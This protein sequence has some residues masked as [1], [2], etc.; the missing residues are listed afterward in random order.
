MKR[1]AP[2]RPVRRRAP[3]VVV[4]GLLLSVAGCPGRPGPG[5][6]SRGPAGAPSS[7]HA[8][9]AGHDGHAEADGHDDHAGHDGHD[10]HAE[11]DAGVVTLT[12]AQAR[13][14]DVRVQ[15]A[16]P[17]PIAQVLRLRAVV[18]PN[19]DAQ[20]HATPRVAGLV[21]AIHK[22]LGD[23]VEAGEVLCE[24]DSVDLG[25]AASEYLQARALLQVQRELL[26][27][28]G[29]LLGRALE[30]ARTVVAR[31]RKLQEQAV[32][33]IR[34]LY[35][36]E[37]RLAEAQLA[38]DR[39]LLEL[40][41]ALRTLEVQA[42]VAHERLLVL[43]LTAA[44]VDGLSATQGAGIGRY[45]LRAAAP[46]VIVDRHVTQSEYVGPEDTLFLLQDGARVWVEAKVYEKDLRAVQVGQ[47]VRVTLEA[48]PGVALEGAVGL[49]GPSVDPTTRAAT[50]RVVLDNAVPGA[51]QPAPLRPGM[52]AKVEVTVAERTADVVLPE[53][54]VVHEGR[55]TFVFVRTG[56]RTYRRQAVQ[57]E[58]A[59]RGVVA[60]VAGLPAGAEVAV[61]GTFTLESVS[62]A[63][64]LGGGHSH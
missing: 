12:E 29:E 53:A 7:G 5:S 61:T 45:E 36:A 35:E 32:S 60:V 1:N 59:A 26:A 38:R 55:A 9:H 10:D 2:T 8:G 40:E 49:I 37:Q 25:Q 50:V 19:R 46:G 3:T 21:R 58:D 31:E 64:E 56:P 34:A 13:S 44:E 11:A 20:V 28:E 39:R 17:G 57:V 51:A 62:R 30:L 22:G 23:R 48:Y 43:G 14:A 18:A 24:L 27:R 16:G 6:A 33:T 42:T 47:P 52:F 63:G 4:A 54:A 15:V 41:A